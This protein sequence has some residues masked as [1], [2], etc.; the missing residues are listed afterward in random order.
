MMTKK[1]S[2]N[3]FWTAW[4]PTVHSPQS[5][6]VE[7]TGLAQSTVHSPAPLKGGKRTWT[8]M[9]FVVGDKWGYAYAPTLHLT[10]HSQQARAG[11]KTNEDN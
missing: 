10:Q 4:T 7:W 2:P 8:G 11:K 9:L 6:L 3:A 1:H 5:R